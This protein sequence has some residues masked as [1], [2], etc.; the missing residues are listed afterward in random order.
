MSL[1]D[2][3]PRIIA[4]DFDGTIVEH[5]FPKIGKLRSEIVEMMKQEKEN[6]TIIII[7]TCRKGIFESRM[8]KFLDENDIPYDY[9]NENYPGLDFITSRKIYADCYIDDKGENVN[10]WKMK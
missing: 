1:K 5:R 2:Y 3:K 10:E 8:K 9:I 7:W 6:G 4:V